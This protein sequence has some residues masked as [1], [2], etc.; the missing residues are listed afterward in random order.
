MAELGARAQVAVSYS[1][2]VKTA[3]QMC[4]IFLLTWHAPMWGF[5]IYLAGLILLYVAT[6]LTLWSMLHYLR[7]AWPRLS[8]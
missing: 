7:L 1:G 8:A 3:A 5:D 4:A 2:K 6:A